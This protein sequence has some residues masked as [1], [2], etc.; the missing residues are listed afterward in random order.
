MKN[1]LS[2]HHLVIASEAK[3]SRRIVIVLTISS[4]R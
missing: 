1:T 4:Y 2:V 3:Q